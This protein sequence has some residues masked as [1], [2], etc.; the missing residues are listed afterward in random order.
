M[1]V[2]APLASDTFKFYWKLTN[3]MVLNIKL[4]VTVR[5]CGLFMYCIGIFTM[6]QSYVNR[7]PSCNKNVIEGTR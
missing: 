2:Y 7:Y 4:K 3:K 1:N 5:T 6:F